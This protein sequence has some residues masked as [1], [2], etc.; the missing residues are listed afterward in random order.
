MQQ[1][2]LHLGQH[3]LQMGGNVQCMHMFSH[4]MAS[5]PQGSAVAVAMEDL[6]QAMAATYVQD[7]RQLTFTR[8]H[9]S[10]L[11]QEVLECFLRHCQGHPGSP[12]E[13]EEQVLGNV[14]ARQGIH[15]ISR[16]VAGSTIQP[17]MLAATCGAPASAQFMQLTGLLLK[18]QR[19]AELK[20]AEA[21]SKLQRVRQELSQVAEQ[22][23]EQCTQLHQLRAR[24]NRALERLFLCFEDAIAPQLQ[25]SRDEAARHVV[26]G[27]A[28][29]AAELEGGASGSQQHWVN[30][31]LTNTDALLS[32]GDWPPLSCNRDATGGA[33][34][35]RTAEGSPA[36]DTLAACWAKLGVHH[37]RLDIVQGLVQAVLG[38]RL[39]RDGAAG[40]A[41]HLPQL[42]VAHIGAAALQELAV[43]EQGAQWHSA[44]FTAQQRILEGLLARQ[45]EWKYNL[46]AVRFH[47]RAA[48]EYV[49]GLTEISNLHMQS[50]LAAAG[51]D[52]VP[53]AAQQPV[54]EAYVHPRH[55]GMLVTPGVVVLLLLEVVRMGCAHLPETGMSL[56]TRTTESP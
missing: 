32:S 19:K 14:G 15:C 17:R 40:L 39:L 16:Y 38:G 36:L 53:D 37:S 25:R 11:P 50:G 9:L 18:H 47:M 51:A 46:S 43:L 54:F 28:I 10:Q 48:E 35:P 13:V 56:P 44:A 31:S 49:Q 23:S 22:I 33:M 5:V 20:M 4:L 12:Q 8:Q 41:Q 7:A 29:S 55:P 52:M 2:L 24:H 6:L 34:P 26:P 1:Q 3:A 45:R 42:Q 30:P 21:A 27:K